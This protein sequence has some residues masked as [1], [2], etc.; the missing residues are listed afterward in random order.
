LEL[1]ICQN[2]KDILLPSLWEAKDHIEVIHLH[3]ISK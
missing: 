2:P 1:P 3:C